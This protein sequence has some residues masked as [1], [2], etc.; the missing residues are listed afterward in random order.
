MFTDYLKKSDSEG[1]EK[2]VPSILATNCSTCDEIGVAIKVGK[3]IFHPS[4]PEHHIEYIELFG[5]TDAEKLVPLTKFD[6]SKENTIPYVKTHI[7]KGLFKKLIALSYCNVH[8]L[9]ENE[10]T[11]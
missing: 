11:V 1:K 3:E 7:K 6:L 9:W 8:G 5:V 2:H 4:L 10:I